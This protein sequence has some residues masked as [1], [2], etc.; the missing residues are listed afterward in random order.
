MAQTGDVFTLHDGEQ[1]TVRIP[2]AETNG[3]LLEVEAEWAPVR[4][5]PPVHLHPK[6]AERFIIREGELTVE[7]DGVTHRAGPGETI[8][9]PRGAVH[10]MWNSGTETTRAAWQVR[11]ALRTEDFF[12]AVHSVRASGRHGKN[13][14]L[15][16]LGAGMVLRE[17]RDEFRMPVP[18]ALQRPALALLAGLAR[19]RGYPRLATA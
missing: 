9:V 10:K 12:A 3:E 11:P 19:L 17:Y 4:L 6:Q 1:V 5:D 8:E 16:P 13:G 15:T 7:I 14:M 2:G 18:A